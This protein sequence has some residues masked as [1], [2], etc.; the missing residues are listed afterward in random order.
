MLPFKVFLLLRGFIQLH[1]WFLHC[2]SLGITGRC[3]CASTKGKKAIL[4]VGPGNLATKLRLKVWMKL[5]PHRSM[6][7]KAEGCWAPRS[8]QTGTKCSACLSGSLPSF[9]I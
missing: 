1:A 4:E 5:S 7:A 2:T 9:V 8:V 6:V 3:L